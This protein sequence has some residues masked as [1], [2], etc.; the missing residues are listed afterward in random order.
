MCARSAHAVFGFG[1]GLDWKPT[2]FVNGVPPTRIC[3]ACGLVPPST[4]TLPC[5]HALC[6]TCYDRSWDKH[7]RCPLDNEPFLK[8]DV[9]WSSF[10]LDSL[11]ARKI[12]CW[13]AS[14]GCDAVGSASDILEHMCNKCQY[15][16]IT[17]LRCK[18]SMSHKDVV[19]HLE[20]PSCRQSPVYQQVGSETDAECPDIREALRHI[21]AT[22]SALQASVEC[23]TSTATGRERFRHS[24]M[25]EVPLV[26]SIQSLDNT[27]KENTSTCIAAS[28]EITKTR[29]LV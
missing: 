4:A 3:A 14:K 5:R 16:P 20:S 9:V 7:K 10:A 8:E 19:D 29:A 25:V 1:C 24:A 12:E 28:N 22:V 13:N 21:E 18:R 2:V 26:E 6:R 27:L 17:C 11:L 15:Q 23:G